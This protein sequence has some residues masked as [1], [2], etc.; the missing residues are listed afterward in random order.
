MVDRLEIYFALKRATT[1]TM[2]LAQRVIKSHDGVGD[3]P[4]LAKCAGE[5]QALALELAKGDPRIQQQIEDN[6]A[7]NRHDL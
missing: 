2:L 6:G 3:A 4:E 5:L 7:A 1:R